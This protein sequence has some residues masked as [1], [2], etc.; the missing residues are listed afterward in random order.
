M[1]R[2]SH[3][4]W[5]IHAGASYRLA[6][7]GDVFV[8]VADISE[9]GCCVRRPS[10]NLFVG[11]RVTVFIDGLDPAQAEVRWHDRGVAAGFLFEKAVDAAQLDL[12]I[13]LCAGRVQL[14]PEIWRVG[15]QLNDSAA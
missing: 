9:T 13:R 14:V 8:S 6:N 5:A 7:G 15:E 12:L 4:G 2:R 10:R 1:S 3:R 11:D